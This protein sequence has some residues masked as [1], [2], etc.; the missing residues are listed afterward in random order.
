MLLSWPVQ[1]SNPQSLDSTQIK[2]NPE[3][4]KLDVDALSAEISIEVKSDNNSDNAL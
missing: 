1:I 2:G 3:D 4:L